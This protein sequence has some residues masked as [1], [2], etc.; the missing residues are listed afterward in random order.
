MRWM[1]IGD[2]DSLFR[3]SVFPISFRG[4]K[5]AFDKFIRLEGQQDGT[6]LASLTWERYVPT[7]GHV[8]GYGCRLAYRMN[9]GERARG[10][11]EESRRRVYCGAYHLRG[12]SVRALAHTDGLDAVLSAD[13]VHRVENGEIAHTDLRVHLQPGATAHVEATKTM[14][15]DRLWSACSGPLR[16]ICDCDIDLAEHPSTYLATPPGGDYIDTRS[17]IRRLWCLVRFRV[18]SWAWRN[19]CQRAKTSLRTKT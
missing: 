7:D 14:I 8:H 9:E 10:R 15:V 12:K 19:L 1:R 17:S 16:H 11:F 18:L 2:R 6:I 13:V 3:Q 5:F 4:K